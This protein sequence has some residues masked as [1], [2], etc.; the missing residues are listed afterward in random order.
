[1][2]ARPAPTHP[3]WA[4]RDLSR[5]GA[6]A[7]PPSY[8]ALSRLIRT[9]LTTCAFENITK[10]YDY[11]RREETGWLIPPIETF[12]DHLYRLDAGGTCFTANSR[13]HLLLRQLGYDAYQVR[14]ALTTWG[15]GFN[16]PR[17]ASM[18]M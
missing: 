11:K 18:S 1:M 12:V 6:A 9:P 13:F 2:T 17:D 7:E 10:L 4:N 8:S 16:C 5:L 15:S 3:V 14:W